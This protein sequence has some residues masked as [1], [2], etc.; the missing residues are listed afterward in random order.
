MHPFSARDNDL[1]CPHPQKI[2]PTRK[3][4]APALGKEKEL[5]M[6]HPWK[7]PEREH[8]G[9]EG[10]KEG[11][12]TKGRGG[13]AQLH[14]TAECIARLCHPRRRHHCCLPLGQVRV[15]SH[16]CAQARLRSLQRLRCRGNQ[17]P[18]QNPAHPS[19]A[20]RYPRFRGAPPRSP[21]AFSPSRSGSSAQSGSTCPGIRQP[22]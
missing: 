19:S 6:H 5:L 18:K 20:P 7:E 10:G 21:S 1:Y 12:R 22:S 15:T 17:M 9:K 4:D 8:R 16:R 3:G 2:I 11:G 14:L 13:A